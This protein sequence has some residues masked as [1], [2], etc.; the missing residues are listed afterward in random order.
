M[1]IKEKQLA[2]FTV[3]YLLIEENKLRIQVYKDSVWSWSQIKEPQA[4][5]FSIEQ[6]A[7]NAAS[8]KRD[9]KG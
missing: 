5:K 7:F 1:I 3:M 2:R 6:N 4:Y 8:D 9:Y